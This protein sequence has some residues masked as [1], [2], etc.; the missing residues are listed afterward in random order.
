MG[1]THFIHTQSLT[2]LIFNHLISWHNE[3]I[4]GNRELRPRKTKG[5]GMWANER[6]P[7]A[8]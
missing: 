5:L 3:Q 1:E 2:R 4:G 6:Q 8:C 7:E